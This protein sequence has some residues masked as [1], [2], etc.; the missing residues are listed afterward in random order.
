MININQV[1]VSGGSGP[2]IHFILKNT[3]ASLV[4]LGLV[5][6]D[7]EP[8]DFSE[9]IPIIIRDLRIPR[10]HSSMRFLLGPLTAEDLEVHGPGSFLRI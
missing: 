4:T 7:A 6:C 5:C 10:C 3:M 9:M 1:R 2:F 8:Q